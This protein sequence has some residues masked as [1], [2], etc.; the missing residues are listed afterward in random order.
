MPVGTR[1]AITFVID[2]TEKTAYNH[3]D[4]YPDGLGTDVLGWARANRHALICD[5]H[6]GASGGPVDLA[7]KLRVVDPG[8]TPTSED[9]ERIARLVWPDTTVGTRKLDDWYVL[10]RNT[11]GDPGEMLR[12]GVIEDAANF[13]MDGLYCEWVYVLDL[14]EKVLEVHKGCQAEPH[15]EGR[16]AER[17]RETHSVGDYYP[18]RRIASFPFLALPGDGDFLKACGV[19]DDGG[20]D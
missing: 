7:R 15:T 10:L 20:D 18:A 17:E 14:D 11:Q 5:L 4:S 8:S 9:I 1:G 19:G 13:P 12:I 6:R 2:G 16:F 3:S